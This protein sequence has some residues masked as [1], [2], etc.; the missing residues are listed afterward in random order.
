MRIE[1]DLRRGRF[2]AARPQFSR[3][4]AAPRWALHC[5]KSGQI[6]RS[7]LG[8]LPRGWPPDCHVS[9]QEEAGSRESPRLAAGW[10]AD[11][12]RRLAGRFRFAAGSDAGPTSSATPLPGSARA[13]A[14]QRFFIG[15]CGCM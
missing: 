5:T 6:Q 13:D 7:R 14:R 1:E 12:F 15:E 8:N 4:G 2:W 10:P 3:S 11:C 9:S